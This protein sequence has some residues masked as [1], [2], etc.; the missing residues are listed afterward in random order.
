MK[1]IQLILSLV[2]LIPLSAL[3]Q[4]Y[5]TLS[6]VIADAQSGQLLKGIDVVVKDK[7]TG[8]ISDYKGSYILYLDSGEYEISY[9][10]SGYK[11]EELK[12]DL[13]HDFVQAVELQPNRKTS[14]NKACKKFKLFK[15]KK[16]QKNIKEEIQK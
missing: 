15:Q 7:T 8:T 9:S 2:L 16:N 1:R 13:D 5:Y 12:V 6:G 4:S 11:K 14:S 3:S 10:A